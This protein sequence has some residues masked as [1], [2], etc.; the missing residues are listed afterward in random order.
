MQQETKVAFMTQHTLDWLESAEESDEL[1]NAMMTSAVDGIILIDHQGIIQ[2]MNPAAETLFGYSIS[3]TVGKNVSML[4]PF[5]ERSEHDGYLHRFLESGRSSI[6]G[7]MREVIGQHRDGHPIPLELSVSTFRV[8]EK[9]FFSGIL[10]DVSERKEA[11]RTL[12]EHKI[13]LEKTVKE[14]TRELERVN[15]RLNQ[16][17]AEIQKV[18]QGLKLAAKVFEN[19]GEA[20]VITDV[21]ARIIDINRA[22]EKITGYTRDEVIGNNP[23]VH[24][25]GRHD[26]AFY[27]DMWQSLMEE[28]QWSGEI[29][30]RRK[31]GRVYPKWLTI[32]AVRDLGGVVTH[33]VGIFSDITEMKET[34]R[35]LELLAY[36]D[37]LTELP[38]R[39]L[40]HD[41]L[42]QELL[43]MQRQGQMVAVL[44]VDLDRFK[45]VNDTLGHAAGDDLLQEVAKRIVSCVRKSDTVARIGGDEFTVILTELEKEEHAAQVAKNII[46]EVNRPVEINGQDVYVGA[47]IG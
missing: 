25:S 13:Q 30:D 9:I 26:D 10:H 4:M 45:H 44:F 21:N 8:K 41:R 22:F 35:R 27:A 18:S 12:Q 28:G 40:F 46:R 6:V 14:R 7:S 37:S 15:E 36:Y 33:Y 11:E 20:I 43:L 19:A 29:W 34:E 3:D 5:P 39:K 31:D 32:N 16:Q 24:K 2:T 23:N 1:F 38:N 17:L 42:H 47:S